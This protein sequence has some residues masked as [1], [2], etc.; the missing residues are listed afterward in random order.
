[1]LYLFPTYPPYRSFCGGWMLSAGALRGH[2]PF[3]SFSDF[4]H[5]F[6]EPLDSFLRRVGPSRQGVLREADEVRPRLC[7]SG[8]SG[9]ACQDAEVALGAGIPLG[10]VFF[11]GLKGGPISA[12]GIQ[13]SG[14]MAL[15]ERH[16]SLDSL[17]ECR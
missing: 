11:A 3:V 10:K 12:T 14:V 6:D 2:K 15:L 17:P 1:M 8:F 5:G 7:R 13:P 4:F 9:P 16:Q